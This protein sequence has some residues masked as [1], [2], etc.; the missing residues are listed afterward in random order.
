LAGLG[1]ANP[2]SGAYCLPRLMYEDNNSGGERTAWHDQRGGYG[3]L[4]TNKTRDRKPTLVARS[5]SVAPH[6][7]LTCA[8]A[9]GG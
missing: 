1:L 7:L 8:A 5:L 3:A 2:V 4:V 6:L 9:S